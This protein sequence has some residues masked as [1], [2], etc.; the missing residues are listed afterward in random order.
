MALVPV[1]SLLVDSSWRKTSP[2]VVLLI[3]VTTAL[4]S[5]YALVLTFCNMWTELVFFH[6]RIT[7]CILRLLSSGRTPLNCL[8]LLG[9][10]VEWI[11]Q[12][13]SADSWSLLTTPDLKIWMESGTTYFAVVP[14]SFLVLVVFYHWLLESCLITFIGFREAALGIWIIVLASCH[15]AHRVSSMLLISVGL[16]SWFLSLRGHRFSL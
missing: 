11:G 4:S 6:F 9:T 2:F 12:L 16:S 5:K 14:R 7:L 13:F 10:A 8:V 1:S 3:L 15:W